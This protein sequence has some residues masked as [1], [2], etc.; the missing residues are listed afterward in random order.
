MKKMRYSDVDAELAALEQRELALLAELDYISAVLNDI[1]AKLAELQY[2][3]RLCKQ[4]I[5]NSTITH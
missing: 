3:S 5:M 1:A 2:L 4:P